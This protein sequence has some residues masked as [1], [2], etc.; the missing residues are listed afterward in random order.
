[1][2]QTLGP[3]VSGDYRNLRGHGLVD[4]QA[5]T[6][7][8]SERNNG[9]RGFP[10]VGANVADGA[11]YPDARILRSHPQDIRRGGAA[12]DY[13]RA[14]GTPFADKRQNF[15]DEPLYTVNIRHPIHGPGEYQIGCGDWT[16]G[17]RKII[18]IHSRGHGGNAG[19]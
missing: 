5:C 6:A 10:Q 9:D 17:W 18:E 8:D 1:N 11:G 2:V 14:I 19:N 4:L 16:S 12:G 15:F 3:N 7:S 13:Q